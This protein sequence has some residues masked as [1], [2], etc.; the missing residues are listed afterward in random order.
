MSNEDKLSKSM[1]KRPT[2]ST[3]SSSSLI[4][5]EHN[6]SFQLNSLAH[7]LIQN[8]SGNIQNLSSSISSSFSVHSSHSYSL[9]HLNTN[10][11]ETGRY[12]VLSHDH[13]NDHKFENNWCTSCGESS[14]VR[15]T[16]IELYFRVKFY[17]SDTLLLRSP[18]TRRLYYLQLRQ[19]YLTMNHN[20]SEENYFVLASLAIVADFGAY[21]PVKHVGQYFDINLYFPHWV[22]LVFSKFFLMKNL[23]L[24]NFHSSKRSLTNWAASIFTRQYHE[25][26][27]KTAITRPRVPRPNFAISCRT[28]IIRSICT[29]IICTRLRRSRREL[30]AWVWRL[31]AYLFL[32]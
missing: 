16:S 1:T 32:T 17:V 6:N 3:S 12:Q 24:T 26:T 8:L 10:K 22:T 11:K 19:N 25:C 28:T 29:C 20:I 7:R 21:D 30:F 23:F 27:R 15:S 9:K 5:S 13:L 18:Q 31:K 4:A 2:L 14:I